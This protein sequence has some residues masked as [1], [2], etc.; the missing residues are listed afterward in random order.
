MTTTAYR[1]SNGTEGAWFRREFCE[2][3]KNN[4]FESALCEILIASM[5]YQ[6]EDDEY[7]KEWIRHEDG[8]VECTAFNAK[9]GAK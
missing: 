8:G 3:C 4:D 7:P 2:K 1:P 6:V 5:I 9:D